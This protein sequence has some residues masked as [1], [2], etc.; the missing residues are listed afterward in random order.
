MPRDILPQRRA[1]A[2]TDFW[3]GSFLYSATIGFYPN[4][5]VGEVFLS[6]SKTGT[7]LDVATRDSA[8]ALSFALQHGA[9]VAAV[10]DAMTRGENGAPHGALGALLDI[11]AV[12][13]RVMVDLIKAQVVEVTD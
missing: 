12:E 13:E 6:A 10:R 1:S 4:G 11:L 3:H 8:I 2:R 9:T 7:E 5:R